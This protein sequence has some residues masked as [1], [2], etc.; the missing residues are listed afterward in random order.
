MIE[1][2]YSDN[3]QAYGVSGHLPYGREQ[4]SGSTIRSSMVRVAQPLLFVANHF[5]R[6]GDLVY[7][8]KVSEPRRVSSRERYPA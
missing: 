8:Q 3:T 4:R 6:F 1:P 2:S 7:I 5:L